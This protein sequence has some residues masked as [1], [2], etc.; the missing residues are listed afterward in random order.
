MENFDTTLN[1]LFEWLQAHPRYACLS[2]GG[3]FLLLLFGVIRGWKWTYH[4]N[5]HTQAT[6]R[7]ETGEIP[8]RFWMGVFY[9]LAAVLCLVLAFTA[10]GNCTEPPA[11]KEA[12]QAEKPLPADPSFSRVMELPLHEALLIYGETIRGYDSKDGEFVLADALISEFRV[13]L[14]NIYERDSVVTIREVTWRYSPNERITVWYEQQPD[15][16]CF[17]KHSTIYSD[18]W[19]F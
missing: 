8:W 11:A 2:A 9:T 15:N 10:T 13:E 14:L 18:D 1:T 7:H 16:T 4:P 6:L 5:G 19:E 12:C 17:P 3:V